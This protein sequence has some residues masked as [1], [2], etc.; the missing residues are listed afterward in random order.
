MIYLSR[1][2]GVRVHVNPDLIRTIES[3]PDTVLT[4]TD[5]EKVMVKDRPDEIV[6][7]IVRFRRI[8]ALVPV[9]IKE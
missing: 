9:P 5:G 1:L 7:K 4:F 2:N 3:A 8:C 6:E